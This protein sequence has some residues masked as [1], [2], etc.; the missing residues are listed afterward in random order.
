MEWILWAPSTQ[1]ALV[2]IPEEAELL[3]PM[4]RKAADRSDVHLMAYA[5]PVTKAMLPFNRFQCYNLPPLPD[6]HE[7]PSWFRTELGLF[8]G[9]LYVDSAEGASLAD[10]LRPQVGA[11]EST[12]GADDAAF[13][14]V[15]PGAGAVRFAADPAAF[16]L[17]W[18]SVRRKVQD[19]LHTPMGYICMGKTLDENK[20]P[21]GKE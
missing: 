3:I 20:H 12:H 9:C 4:L 14:P 2:V 8:A 11:T 18:L 6:G 19:I 16:V 15:V 7:F 17:E 1:T 5:A 10:Y 21:S 13:R